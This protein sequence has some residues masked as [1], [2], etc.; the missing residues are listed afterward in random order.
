MAE[1]TRESLEREIGLLEAQ[2]ERMRSEEAR[3]DLEVSS[4]SIGRSSPKWGTCGWS[5]RTTRSRPAST[6]PARGGRLLSFGAGHTEADAV[7]FLPHERVLF[8]GDLAVVGVQ[9]TLGS[10]DPGR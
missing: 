1:L 7:L 3:K 10:G 8:A 6:S 9:P 5:P 4:R 2:R